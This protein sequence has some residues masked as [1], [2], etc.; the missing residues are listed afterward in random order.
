M[1]IIQYIE[2]LQ[3]TPKY[4]EEEYDYSSEFLEWFY[5][6]IYLQRGGQ[7]YL[8]II[9]NEPGYD[10]MK[11]LCKKLI[12]IQTAKV[13]DSDTIHELN[14]ELKT[15]TIETLLRHDEGF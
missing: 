5:T 9:A 14:E 4:Q 12:N 10:K 11:E 13:L 2:T 15:W 1:R 7:E 6:N 8:N 3:T